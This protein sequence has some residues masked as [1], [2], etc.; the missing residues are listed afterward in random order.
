MQKLVLYASLFVLVLGACSKDKFQD[1]PNIRI[2]S[3]DPTQVPLKVPMVMDLVFTD[4]QGDLDSVFLI[5]S[6]LNKK[7]PSGGLLNNMF[8]P[9]KLPDFPEKSKGEIQLTLDYETEL[10]TAQSARDQQGAPNNKEPD[11]I[12]FNIVVK[13]KAGNLSDTVSTDPLVIERFN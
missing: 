3:I 6:R 10:K 5:K 12:M 8:L 11:T 13:D 9:F 1:K 7:P 4:N 2:K